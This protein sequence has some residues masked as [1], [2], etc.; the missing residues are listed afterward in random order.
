MSFINLTENCKSNIQK[1][2]SE[3]G[4]PVDATFLRIAVSGQSCSG[5]RF[6][7]YFDDIYHAEHDEL[8]ET[9]GIKVITSK[10]NLEVLSGYTIDYK[11]NEEVAGFVF[12]TPLKVAG[13]SKQGGCCG[14]GQGSC[15]T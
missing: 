6:S 11:K 15:N 3:G 14:G 4:H 2:L 5:P 1:F 13:C 12:D 8:L 9:D 7:L 10:S